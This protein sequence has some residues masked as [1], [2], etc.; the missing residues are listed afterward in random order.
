MKIAKEE[1]FGPVMSI[2]KWSDEDDVIKRANSLPYGL[3]AGIVTKS[4]DKVLKLVPRLHAGTVY[5]NC[6][7][8][9]EPCTP[10]GGVKDSGIGKDL[11][12]EGLESYLITKTVVMKSPV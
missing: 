6:Y 8:Y 3:G 11:G 9:Q 12:D 1:I 7:D 5:V 10:F 4:I 2:F